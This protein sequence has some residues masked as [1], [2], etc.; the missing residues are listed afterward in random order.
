MLY[1][2]EYNHFPTEDFWCY[3]DGKTDRKNLTEYLEKRYP[4][5]KRRKFP[6]IKEYGW[7]Y[8]SFIDW[9]DGDYDH[10]NES[11]EL[12]ILNPKKVNEIIRNIT[13]NIPIE[14]EIIK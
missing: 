7:Y 2:K 1:Q 8:I 11:W 13:D 12:M 5:I 9:D 10:Y 3:I 6:D 4:L 14:K